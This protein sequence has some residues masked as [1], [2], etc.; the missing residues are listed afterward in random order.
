M[1]GWLELPATSL[2]FSYL[3]S[4]LARYGIATEVK[5]PIQNTVHTP[6]PPAPLP[7]KGRGEQSQKDMGNDEAN[8][9]RLICSLAYNTIDDPLTA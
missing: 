6:S 8:D 9:V 1:R 7:E 4:F 2:R 5:I 3:F